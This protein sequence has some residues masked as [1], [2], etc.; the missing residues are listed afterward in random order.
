MTPPAD[1]DK[2]GEGTVCA[3][4]QTTDAFYIQEIS[5][6]RD[7][8]AR[9]EEWILNYARHTD[10]CILSM[11]QAGRPASDGGYE[12]KYNGVWYPK[13]K[14]PKCECGL[15]ELTS[16]TPSVQGE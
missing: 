8:A 9:M 10:D 15:D 6:L 2:T 7:R 11:W 3:K 5:A 1:A 4:C 16:P 13:D 12:S 14:T